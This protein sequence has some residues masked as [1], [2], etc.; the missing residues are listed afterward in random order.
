MWRSWKFWIVVIPV[1]LVVV[2]GGYIFTHS[3]YGIDKN[4]LPHFIE[5][6]FVDLSRFYSISKLRSG[7][8][9]DF[10]GNGETC[11]SMKHYFT[12]QRNENVQWREVNGQRL[13]PLPDGKTD[14]PIYSPVDGRILSM[15]DENTPIGKQISIIPTRENQFNIRLF[16]IFPLE[17]IGTG[18]KVKA[19]QQIGVIGADQGTDIAIQVGAMPWNDTFISYFDVM[20]DSLFATYQARGAI[21][22]SDFI[23][24]KEY[25]DANPLQCS[26]ETFV[27]PDNYDYAKDDFHLTGYVES[28]FGG[29]H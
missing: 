12:P 7:E 1:G 10:S 9:H 24:T 26:G 3:G 18:S 28:Q 17:S 27:R 23:F 8:G 5:N 20:S 13:P 19:G 2:L 14:I 29:G 25:R 4:N 22:R 6:D 16:H 11:R 15:S 21:S